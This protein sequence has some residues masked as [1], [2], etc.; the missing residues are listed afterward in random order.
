MRPPNTIQKGAFFGVLAACLV[1]ALT[2]MAISA[3]DQR[4]QP[5]LAHTHHLQ[6]ADTFAAMAPARGR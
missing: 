3:L 6:S 5:R 4:P 2:V 1:M